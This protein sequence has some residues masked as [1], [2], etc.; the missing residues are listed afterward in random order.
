MAEVGDF[1][2]VEGSGAYC[3]SM[4]TKN[5]NSFPEVRVVVAYVY[6]CARLFFSLYLYGCLCL[7][8]SELSILVVRRHL[9]LT[10]LS[11]TSLH[12][13]APELLLTED[14]ELHVIRA[15]QP[16]V[17]IWKN[18]VQLDDKVLS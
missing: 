14:G 18:E 9:N 1:L 7:R 6:V 11:P 4:S 8:A 12:P 15:R 16:L 3:S 13:K 5:Y 2:V 10:P 17:E